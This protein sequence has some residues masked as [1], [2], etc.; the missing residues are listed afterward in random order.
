MVGLAIAR[1]LLLS[2][3]KKVVLV[4]KERQVCR[5]QSDL[6]SGVIH[7][8]IYYQPGSLRASLCVRGSAEMY[9]FCEESGVTTQR[10]GKYIVAQDDAGELGK[11][12]LS[13]AVEII[14]SSSSFSLLL[15]SACR[16]FSSAA[17]RM[18]CELKRWGAGSWPNMGSGEPPASGVVILALSRT[19][20]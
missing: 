10:C 9:R 17:K 16:L 12:R 7:C 20:K 2:G 5:H 13:G 3:R 15:Q 11:R 18:A 6:N 4:E 19:G 14:L 8:G 1:Q